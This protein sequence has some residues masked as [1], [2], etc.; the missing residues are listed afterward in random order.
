M[1]R[2]KTGVQNAV[3]TDR[4]SDVKKARSIAKD[5]GSDELKHSE[6]LRA[7]AWRAGDKFLMETFDDVAYYAGVFGKDHFRLVEIA[8]TAEMQGRG[9]GRMM[10]RRI[11]QKCRAR[12]V[13]K[14]TLRA[15]AEEG[16]AGFYKKFGAVVTG[17][18]D[19]D[20]EM[21]IRL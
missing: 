15:S 18:H 20:Y 11:V 4:A 2:G 19:G 10:M 17:L 12:G 6:Y 9:Y 14:I 21:E 5:S 1:E 3:Q 7:A 8:V 13:H 16:A